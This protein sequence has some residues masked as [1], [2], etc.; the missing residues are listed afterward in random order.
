MYSGSLQLN[1][2][3]LLIGGGTFLE[4]ALKCE[5]VFNL[6]FGLLYTVINY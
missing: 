5:I 3:D 6:F 1:V 4:V 2:I